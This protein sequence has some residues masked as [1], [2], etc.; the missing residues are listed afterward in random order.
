MTGS[1][2]M[3]LV[4]PVPFRMGTSGLMIEGQATNGI[5]QWAANFEHVTVAAPV[6]PSR[7]AEKENGLVWKDEHQLRARQRVRL[8]PLPWASHPLEFVRHYR[9]GKRILRALIR[10]SSHLQFAIGALI[11]DWGAVAAEEAALQRRKFAVHADRVEHE[12]V[13]QV[14][15]QA[16]WRGRIKAR[17]TAS[18]MREYHRRIIAKCSLGL[19]HGSECFAAY[20]P[21]CSESFVIHD[22]HTAPS[23]AISE[24]ALSEKIARAETAR[25]LNICYA[26]RLDPMKAPL[27]WLKGIAVARDLKAPIRAVWYGEGPLR[28]EVEREIHKLGLCDIVSLPGFIRDR[29]GVLTAIRDAH[30]MAFTHVTPES[31]RC[32]LEALV[33]GTPI[34]GYAN[35]FATDLTRGLGGGRFVPVHDWQK[36]GQTIAS[37]SFDRGAL[38]D[39]IGDA[40]NSGKRFNDV[41][42]FRERSLL[43][44]RFA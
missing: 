13:L 37:L 25:C 41:A 17:I 10:E 16:S 32:L 5:E 38:A 43:V 9:A 1:E 15:R 33:C 11:G 7:L 26:G 19:W 6:L 20:S 31:P 29:G 39:L 44:K 35:K 22:I 2:T 28:S 23:D 27:D 34:V 3:F 18:L 4:V 42:V 24:E 12:V 14:M 30:L 36:L 40:A 8:V 21:L